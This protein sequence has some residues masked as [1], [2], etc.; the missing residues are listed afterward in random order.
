MTST[1]TIQEARATGARK[2]ATKSADE[3]WET[4]PQQPG[5]RRYVPSGQF[6]AFIRVRGELKRECLQTTVFTDAKQALAQ[7]RLDWAK[8]ETLTGSI[9]DGITKYED[10][11]NKNDDLREL[12]KVYNLRLLD[13]IKK[14][15]PVSLE[16]QVAKLTPEDMKIWTDA[17]RSLYAPQFF[18]NCLNVL[19]QI[20]TLAGIVWDENTTGFRSRK[21]WKQNRRGIPRKKLELPTA[22][23]FEKIVWE[24]EH[25]GAGQS[26]D[27][28]AFVR[29]LAYSGTRV[30]EAAQAQWRDVNFET[31]F[32]TIQC[33]K[34]RADSQELLTR[35][36]PLVP[37]METFLKSEIERAKNAKRTLQPDDPICRVMECQKSLTRACK[38]VKCARLTH[39]SLRHLFATFCIEAG[40]DIPT[41]SKWLG[42]SDGGALAMRVYGHLRREHSLKMAQKITFGLPPVPETKQLTACVV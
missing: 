9:Q 21:W 7:K 39:H 2:Q 3:K 6:Y 38:V 5:L 19:R 31:G 17:L 29:F 40:V 41:V 26:K 11:L 15:S 33:G 36:V 30:S 13:R 28:A 24:V 8:P 1:N 16:L 10:E 42:H 27:A 12:S 18:N 22:D 20:V 37:A 32:I 34:R 25:S 4:F 35:D 14:A 23:Q